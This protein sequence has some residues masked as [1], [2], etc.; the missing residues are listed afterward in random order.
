[1]PRSRIPTFT[2]RLEV[3]CEEAG[4]PR[5]DDTHYDILQDTLVFFWHD[6]EFC[7]AAPL[8][9]ASVYGLTADDLRGAWERKFGPDSIA[10]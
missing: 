7:L 3:I 10:A 9:T 1:M 2:A 5:F 8:A 4:L 6:P